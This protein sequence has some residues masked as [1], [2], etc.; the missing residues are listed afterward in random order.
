[1]SEQSV[2]HFQQKKKK[3][4]PK[5]NIAGGGMRRMLHPGGLQA[6]V[7]AVQQLVWQPVLPV[8]RDVQVLDV[9]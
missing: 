9:L 8:V 6:A 3:P 7:D 4:S 1:M 2:A 5:G